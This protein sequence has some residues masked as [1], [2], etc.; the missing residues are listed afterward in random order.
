MKECYN[1]NFKNRL[2]LDWNL[3]STAERVNFI[4]EYIKDK[5]FSSE[6]L[7]MMGNYILW[8]D[9]RENL[10]NFIELP[11]SNSDW[12]KK[13]Q[14]T[15]SLEALLEDPTFDEFRFSIPRL[16][17]QNE[18]FSRVEA[19]EKCPSELKENFKI[20]F[21]EIDELDYILNIYDLKTGKRKNPP[22]EELLKNIPEERKKEL[23][24]KA[25]S[26]NPFTY[27]K[28]R[29]ELVELRR[30]QF[31]LQDIYKTPI[32]RHFPERI[33]LNSLNNSIEL[34][35]LPLGAKK[36]FPEIFIP[37]VN[38]N[39]LEFSEIT[40]KKISNL[41]WED[42]SNI[43]FSFDFR[44]QE[45]VRALLL[46]P[47][48]L[49]SSPLSDTLQYYISEANLNPIYTEILNLKRNKI[50]N[51]NISQY[52]NQKFQKHYTENYISTIFCQK[53]IKKINDAAALHFQII[54]NIFFNEE[55][56]T[57]SK[58]G[59]LLLRTSENFRKR[60]ANKD[61]F[62]GVCRFCEEKLNKI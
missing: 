62:S 33:D 60:K 16:K 57:C 43:N 1:L 47:D 52:I 3:E 38:L 32:C 10:N 28:K 39:P 19:L 31:Y 61:G 18:K 40:K 13:S 22:R 44:D 30:S 37:F 49:E 12:D 50:S 2:N 56:K 23:E 55:F 4:N 7:E 34:N 54:Q 15:E 24:L 59:K 46:D 26:L 42:R 48:F 35:I 27:L 5:N 29:H 41:L 11:R 25:K 6:S 9:K 17:I 36:D 45:S 20:L 53:I 58:C 51:H 8:S 14:K 21:K